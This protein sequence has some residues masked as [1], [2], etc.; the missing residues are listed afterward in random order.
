VSEA[1]KRQ[2]ATLKKGS[3][4]FPEASQKAADHAARDFK[5]NPHYSSD[6]KAILQS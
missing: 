1:R 4:K 6:M 3:E 5:V 2:L